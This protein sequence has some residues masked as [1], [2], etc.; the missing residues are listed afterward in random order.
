MAA[1]KAPA[2]KAPAKKASSSKDSAERKAAIAAIQ[3]DSQTSEKFNL[4]RRAELNA[5]GIKKPKTTALAMREGFNVS[6]PLGK[7]DSNTNRK[8]FNVNASPMRSGSIGRRI[9]EAEI[10]SRIKQMKNKKKKK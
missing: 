7:P 9:T 3:R 2:K 8:G 4:E 5:R 10:Q 6:K 1:K